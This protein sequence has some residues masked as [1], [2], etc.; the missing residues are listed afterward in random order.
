MMGRRIGGGV[1]MGG[2]RLS[3]GGGGK[4]GLQKREAAPSPMGVDCHTQEEKF[5]SLQL[6]AV[7]VGYHWGVDEGIWVKFRINTRIGQ[8]A[9]SGAT[10]TG[11][12]RNGMSAKFSL[13]HYEPPGPIGAAFIKNL[14]PIDI[15]MGPAGSGKTVASSYKGP[16]LAGRWF[17]VCKDGVI[18]VK[19]AVIRDTYR[20]LARTCLASWYEMFPE[21]HPFTV[22]HQGGQDRPVKHVLAFDCLRDNTKCKVELTMEFGAIGDANIETFAKGYELSAVW[23][24][25]CDMLHERVPGLMWSRTGRYPKVSDIA[26]AELARVV[27]PYRAKMQGLGMNIDD[28]ELLLPR[29]A[30]GDCNPPDISNWVCKTGGLGEAKDKNAMYNLFRQPGGLEAKAENRKG[31]P[32]SS[33]EM[34]AATMTNKQDIRRFV[35][36]M[37]GYAQDGVP[38]YDEQFALDVHRGDAPLA[39]VD[40]LPIN[41]GI[42]AGGSPACVIG[43]F[44][45]NGQRRVLREIC[46]SPGT[47]PTRFAEMILEV[48]LT[49]FKGFAINEAYGDPSSFYGADRVAGELA[50]I[51]IVSRALN[52]NINPTPSNEPSLRQEAVRWY[53]SGMIDA[54]TPRYLVDPRCTR[55]IGGF[56]AH[57]KLTK[58]ASIG[59]T[60]KL[61]VVK[62]EYSHIHDAEQYACLGHRGRYGVIEKAANMGRGNNVI[63]MTAIQGRT[64]FDVFA[65]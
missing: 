1:F 16:Y 38:V 55:L 63:S 2:R 54:N 53:L 44:M 62:N 33:Y 20:D 48:L 52:V 24:N 42:D 14:G 43:Q 57:Y 36:G 56:M 47:G 45:P 28:D 31:K 26:E 41:L 32:R 12:A 8:E 18:R 35:H 25:E 29:L 50:W 7:G 23:M 40:G 37:P 13:Q 3:G 46:A 10:A 65:V 22:L 30:W 51:E 61:A 39:P 6:T 58:Q 15:I 21:N 9:W 27:A 17:P 19:V 64:D 11:K 5:G 4:G 34:E 59:Q 49:D 60:D